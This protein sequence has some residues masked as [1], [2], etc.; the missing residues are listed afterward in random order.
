MPKKVYIL[1]PAYNEENSMRPLITNISK[2]M[3]GEKYDYHI[4]VCNDGS[5]D[6]TR[7]ELASLSKEFPFEVLTH[8]LNRGLGE[9]ARDLFERAAELTEPGD[10]I[11]RLDADNTH[12]P[13]NIGNLIRK[14]DEGYDVVTASRF[15]KGGGQHGVDAY[16]AFVSYCAQVFMK[17]LFGFR[18]MKEFSCGFRVYRAEIVKKAIAFYGNNFIQLKGMGFTGTLEKMV[19]FKI[20]GAKFA[21]VGFQLR[22][23]KKTSYSKM[24]TSITTLGYLTMAFLYHWPWGGWRTGYKRL[25]KDYE[26]NNK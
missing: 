7:E 21:E 22:Y 19:K 1:L 2:Y 3:R 9:T 11:V 13:Q 15:Q 24:V 14:L 18:G 8:K 20:L 25:L 26:K 23:D 12:E 10:Y 5:R 17:F 6:R 16:R 4:I